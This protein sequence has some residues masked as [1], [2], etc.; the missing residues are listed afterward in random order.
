V[1][2][3]AVA[4]P[5]FSPGGS[6]DFTVSAVMFRGQRDEEGIAE[7]GDALVEFCSELTGVLF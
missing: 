2:I 3:L 4:A 5:V 7:L 6:I 1:G